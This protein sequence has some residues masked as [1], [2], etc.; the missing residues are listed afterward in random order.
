MTIGFLITNGGPHSVEKWAEATASHIVEVADHVSGEKRGA[1]IK[2]Q[3]AI[4]DVL[5]KHHG[6]AELIKT[7]PGTYEKQIE[8]DT[9]GI[10]KYRFEGTGIVY[11]AKESQFLVAASAFSNPQ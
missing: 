6:A 7:S 3:A 5:E 9:P 10:W 1:A 4:I 11:A 2:L 8:A